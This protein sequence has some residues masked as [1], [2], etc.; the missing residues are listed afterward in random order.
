VSDK[1][2][3]AAFKSPVEARAAV[4]ALED[5]QITA[6]LTARD[7]T[8]ERLCVDAFDS[9][10]DVI[11]DR[12]EAAT[13]IAVLQRLWPQDALTIAPPER[14]PACG[15]TAVSRLPRIRLFL[16]AT[17]ILVVVGSIAGERDLFLLLIVIV[18]ALVLLAPGRRCNACNERWRGEPDPPAAENARENPAASCPK[19]GSEE[20][21]TLSRRREKAITL[22]VNFAIPPT[23]FFWPFRARQR[24]LSCGNEWR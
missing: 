12:A 17:A 4:A 13:A 14:C 20:T 7:H 22:L 6:D 15:S 8:L 23:V 18:G 2:V 5:A 19:C 24:C 1:V 16:I 3:V 11:V 9:G 21:Q 10:Y